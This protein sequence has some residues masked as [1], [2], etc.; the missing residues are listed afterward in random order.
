MYPPP[1]PIPTQMPTASSS[2]AER[3]IPPWANW[4]AN[5]VAQMTINKV[6]IT[7]IRVMSSCR[8]SHYL[9]A[10]SRPWSQYPTWLITIAD[11]P[12]SPHCS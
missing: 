9:G 3:I 7:L 2:K 1:P 10:L 12:T 4:L 11:H 5:N 6:L 8:S